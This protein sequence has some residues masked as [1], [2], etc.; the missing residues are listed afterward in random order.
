MGYTIEDYT[1]GIL[2]GIIVTVVG[3][4]ILYKVI[5]WIEWINKIN[6]DV[7]D[8]RKRIEELEQKNEDLLWGRR[9]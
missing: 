6:D 9:S 8:N 4:L 5:K 7:I 3:G 1:S 2:I